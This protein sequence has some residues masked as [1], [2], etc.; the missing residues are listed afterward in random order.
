MPSSDLL[1]GY[2][3][4]LR[5]ELAAVRKLAT[6]SVSDLEADPRLRTDAAL[7]LGRVLDAARDIAV[8][9][10]GQGAA[11]RPSPAV[12][13]DVLTE[14]AGPPTPPGP[15]VAAALP[16]LTMARHRASGALDL[17]TLQPDRLRRALTS[18]SRLERWL[19]PA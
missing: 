12:A 1:P 13:V 6:R 4:A 19:G 3:A 10:T 7:R 18:A 5:A 11:R 17:A 15:A 9:T 14:G 8:L 2:L 16:L